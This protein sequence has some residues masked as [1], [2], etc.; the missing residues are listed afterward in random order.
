MQI[1]G[2]ILVTFELGLSYVEYSIA[3]KAI[4]EKNYRLAALALS[5]SIILAGFAGSIM[6]DVVNSW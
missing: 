1:L 5:L 3:M 2:L 6:T 4:R